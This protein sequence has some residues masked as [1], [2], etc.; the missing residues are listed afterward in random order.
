M[1]IGPRSFFFHHIRWMEEILHQLIGGK[2]S[3]IY[4][5]STS[6]G[7]AGFRNHPQ[8]DIQPCSKNWIG[9]L[10]SFVTP[11]HRNSLPGYPRTM[12]RI[13]KKNN[14][15]LVRNARVFRSGAVH[16]RCLLFACG[17]LTF[18]LFGIINQHTYCL[19][20]HVY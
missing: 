3:S 12:R 7:G 6:Q 11:R 19:N 2:H 20:Q 15:P 10:V 5:V 1:R 18:L 13:F 14:T 9:K 16:R 8:Y 17:P 4:R